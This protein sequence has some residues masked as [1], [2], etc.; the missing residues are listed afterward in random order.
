MGGIDRCRLVLGW[1]EPARYRLLA[2]SRPGYLG[3][4]LSSGRDPREQAD[5]FA[6]LLDALGID[7]VAHRAP[8]PAGTPAPA[9]H[10]VPGPGRARH[11]RR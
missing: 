8:P 7:R 4:P 9:R 1:V 3:T 6:A 11:P 10:P 2:V 5:L